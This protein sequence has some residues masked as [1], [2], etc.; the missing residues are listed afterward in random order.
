[1][2][3]LVTDPAEPQDHR[4][5]GMDPVSELLELYSENSLDVAALSVPLNFEFFF[6]ILSKINLVL[7]LRIGLQD[8]L[9]VLTMMTVLV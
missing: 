4:N 9:I 1:M 3:T 7:Q 6:S 8:I 2:A 5:L